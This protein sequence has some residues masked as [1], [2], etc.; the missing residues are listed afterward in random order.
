MP[1]SNDSSDL[2][3]RHQDDSAFHVTTMLANPRRGI[4][5]G[6]RALSDNG[7]SSLSEPEDV[8]DNESQGPGTD[9]VLRDQGN[10]DSEAETERLEISPKKAWK[11]STVVPKPSAA[12]TTNGQMRDGTGRAMECAAVNTQVSNWSVEG[13]ELFPA[14]PGLSAVVGTLLSMGDF[15]DRKRKRTDLLSP[16]TNAGGRVEPARKRSSSSRP[17]TRSTDEERMAFHTISVASV[18]EEINGVLMDVGRAEA[19]YPYQEFGDSLETVLSVSATIER[20]KRKISNNEVFEAGE[21]ASKAA[22]G[23]AM[24]GVNLLDGE[25]EADSEAEET[26]EAEAEEEEVDTAAKSEDEREYAIA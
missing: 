7:S 10:L 15:T 22:D 23:S 2:V 1:L 26:V 14:H 6:P 24:T 25:V 9:L 5:G 12:N 20:A 11:P 4:L 8:S 17:E 18:G 16:A 3:E 13:R 21:H 19:L